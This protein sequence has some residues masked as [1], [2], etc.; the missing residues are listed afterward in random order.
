[1]GQEPGENVDGSFS[2]ARAFAAKP[3]FERLL[4]DV[5]TVQQISSVECGGLFEVSQSASS[6]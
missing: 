2:K 3:L 4:A 5:D 1:M 6:R